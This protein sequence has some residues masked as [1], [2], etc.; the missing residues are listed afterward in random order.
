MAIDFEWNPHSKTWIA[1]KVRRKTAWHE[2]RGVDYYDRQRMN[3]P[4]APIVQPRD[5]SGYTAPP[6]WITL[7]DSWGE[8]E[9]VPAGHFH[10][11]GLDGGQPV[12]RL[13]DPPIAQT[14]EYTLERCHVETVCHRVES[15]C[16][17]RKTIRQHVM[18]RWELRFADG[19]VFRFVSRAIAEAALSELLKIRKAKH[20]RPRYGK[21]S[22]E[23]AYVFFTDRK[24][25]TLPSDSM[26]VEQPAETK[27]LETAA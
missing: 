15:R 9:P 5:F 2:H 17:E 14:S 8:W 6:S 11:G 3:Q 27:P 1:R 25:R 23:T 19:A 10:N 4:L 13:D 26:S 21:P 24:L 12:D 18:Y 16:G 22:S 7:P 20:P